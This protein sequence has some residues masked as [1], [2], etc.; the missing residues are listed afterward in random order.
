MQRRIANFLSDLRKGIGQSKLSKHIE[1]VILIGSASRGEWIAGESDIDLLVVTKDDRRRHEVELF[2]GRL[3]GRLGKKH[4]LMLEKT[5]T[6]ERRHEKRIVGTIMKLETLFNFG[7]PYT[8]VSYKD[9]NFLKNRIESPKIQL[10]A[11]FVGSL[12]TYLLAIKQTGRTVYGKD[13]LGLINVRLSYWDRV[14]MAMQQCYIILASALLLPFDCK[15]SVK[16]AMK[17]T[18]YQE[19]LDLLFSGNKIRGYLKDR[20]V[21]DRLFTGSQFMI[22]HLKKT[23]DYR[24]NHNKMEPTKHEAARY[25]LDT[26][27]FIRESNKRLDG[28]GGQLGARIS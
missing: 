6:I 15:Y 5:T 26:I 24:C 23:L 28:L 21:F 9:Y 25:I 27:R 13:L 14:H 4:R 12:N 11:T 1:S 20:K 3:I 19:E 2:F 17:A 10:L 22:R 7:V 8:V 18:L 16:H